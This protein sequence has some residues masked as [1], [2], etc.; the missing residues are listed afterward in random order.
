MQ[1]METV[2]PMLSVNAAKMASVLPGFRR[3]IL[4]V[5][6]ISLLTND[7]KRVLNRYIEKTNDVELLSSFA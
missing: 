6:R 7:S 4:K 5:F 3:Q 1:K 2:A